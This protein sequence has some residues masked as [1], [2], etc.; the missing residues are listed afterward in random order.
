[1]NKDEDGKLTIE[2]NNF[3]SMLKT[4][5][6]T[7]NI[8]SEIISH[9]QSKFKQI[10]ELDGLTSRDIMSSLNVQDNIQN[11]FQ[12][13]EGVGQSG[14]FFF[15]SKDNKLL[16]KTMRGTEKDVLLKMLDDLIYHFKKTQNKS[17]L[18]R[19]YGVFTIK[20]NVFRSVDVIVMQNTVQLSNKSNPCMYFDLK[21]SS[22]GRYT[23]F[24]HQDNLWW[25][26]N[27]Y[28]HKKV[29]KDNNFLQIDNDFMFTL[30]NL[31][32]D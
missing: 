24:N 19:I 26:K 17:L 21:G 1:M 18:A 7:I 2:F 16:I 32:E 3:D 13:G 11:V 27:R 30:L 8:R 15:F 10:M 4:E 14:S 9:C 31:K 22:K 6:D 28:G 5:K 23:K 12:A 25:Q 29:M 20:T